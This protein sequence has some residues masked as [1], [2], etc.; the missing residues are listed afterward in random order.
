MPKIL[1]DEQKQRRVEAATKCMDMLAQDGTLLQKVITGDESWVYLYDPETKHKSQEW[2][3]KC[4]GRPSKALR[5]RSQKKTM[6]VAFFDDFGVI[7]FEF[8]QG[9]VNRFVYCRIL[10]CLREAVRKCHPEMWAAAPDGR[11]HN[12]YLHQDNAPAHN[13]LMTQARLMETGIDLLPHLSYSPDMA[14]SDYFLFP[15]LKCELHGRRFPN[16][17]ALKGEVSRILLDNI[18]PREYEKAM[19]ELPDHWHK[20]VLAG[21]SYFEGIHKLRADNP[22]VE[23]D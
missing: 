11:T 7:H 8:V 12:L 17:A 9:T 2:V 19:L 16:L 10:G 13:A 4:Q 1:S 22:P 18:T 6:L 15:R 5:T 14:P 3:S 23:E 20:C 21:G